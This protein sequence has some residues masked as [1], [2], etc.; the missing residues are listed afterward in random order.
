MPRKIDPNTLNV[1]HG[2]VPSKSVDDNA[3]L[4]PER[5]VDPLR[6]HLHD[7]SRA[8]MASAIGIVDA[9]DCYI[10][11]EVEGALQELCTGWGAGRMNGLIEG[12]YIVSPP[13]ASG[14]PPYPAPTIPSGLE[15]T[16][17][18]P[19][20][21]NPSTVL[22]GAH[23]VDISGATYDFATG[24]DPVGGGP[25]NAAGTYYLY[26]ETDSAS[27]DYRDL[28]AST[29]L[30]T[31][32]QEKILI[33][34]ITHDGTDITAVV[35]CRY[36]VA[37]LDRKLPYTLRAG[38][39]TGGLASNGTFGGENADTWGEALFQTL[40]AALFWITNYDGPGD[41]QEE[42]A[43]VIVRGRQILRGNYLL[44]AGVCLQGSG[45]DAEIVWQ[46]QGSL[47]TLQGNHIRFRDL[48]I[49]WDNDVPTSAVA[50][51]AASIGAPITN[52]SMERC[53]FSGTTLDWT[54]IINA[55]NTADW[56][57]EDCKM[58]GG[59]NGSNIFT[60]SSHDQTLFIE[61][62]IFRGGGAD[63]ADIGVHITGPQNDFEGSITNCAFSSFVQASGP[64]TGWVIR[65]DNGKGLPATLR[66][67]NC[68]MGDE[69]SWPD[70]AVRS[71]VYSDL[72]NTLIRGNQVRAAVGNAGAGAAIYGFYLD[73]ASA[74][75]S[76]GGSSL[77]IDGN[78]VYV[79]KGGGANTWA[80]DEEPT[81]ILVAGVWE[82]PKVVNNNV[83][84]EW[85]NTNPGNTSGAILGSGIGFHVDTATSLSFPDDGVIA[86]NYVANKVLVEGAPNGL[87]VTG[88]HIQSDTSGATVENL[89][90]GNGSRK[91]IITG[92]TFLGSMTSGD[93]ARWGV[94]VLGSESERTSHITVTG[95]TCVN[96]D[97]A[98]IAF[99]GS[100]GDSNIS[101]NVLSTEWDVPV[102]EGI[103]VAGVNLLGSAS[104]ITID[105][106]Q[107]HRWTRGIRVSGYYLNDAVNPAS[108]VVVS[109]NTIEECAEGV[110]SAWSEDT[111]LVAA[112]GILLAYTAQAT[113]VGNNINTVG[114]FL[115][116]ASGVPV[117]GAP[118]LNYWGI[119]IHAFCTE[120]STISDNTI[121]NLYCS[122]GNPGGEPFTMGIYFANSPSNSVDVSAGGHVCS[123]NT[124]IAPYLTYAGMN[125]NNNLAGIGVLAYP[126]VDAI[127]PPIHQTGMVI[128]GN[129]IRSAEPDVD[130]DEVP[131][132]FIIGGGSDGPG[133]CGIFVGAK[134]E[135]ISEFAAGTAQL[136]GVQTVSYTHLTLPTTPYV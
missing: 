83:K 5:D 59:R 127:F 66:V 120:T 40:E 98:G 25:T 87:T 100:V 74:T 30:P 102:G 33:A 65:A 68:T 122:D 131:E 17:V 81:G 35:D 75:Q 67:T 107:I 108:D 78:L 39:P 110:D 41:T 109:N 61:D 90:V 125:R 8:H 15:V 99:T 27:G 51:A 132:A 7:P 121:H 45:V 104:R 89:L 3:F 101:G 32:A 96:H 92:N 85:I 28:V 38:I 97:A 36:F 84:G 113:V 60:F 126:R 23:T 10:S 1:K 94:R 22:I 4:Y 26:V 111:P 55:S 13:D 58:Q 20:T 56:A 43:T 119:G 123:D 95:N 117:P 48:R 91:V 34:Q 86:N 124:I 88:N 6:V 135:D 64:T 44:P 93:G 62:C 42:K 54:S 12:G 31:V 136:D 77:V 29:T 134:Y 128:S 50:I 112:Q 52:F 18:A 2:V 21:G 49:T 14:N 76:N 116:Q 46:G 133:G 130:P 80:V 16:L 72:K 114:L 70:T 47:F 71:G 106:N 103:Q 9:A 69:T 129:L 11:D 37:N 118:T 82:S 19:A 105:G 79:N 53:V 63:G 24:T 73:G 57:I 115:N